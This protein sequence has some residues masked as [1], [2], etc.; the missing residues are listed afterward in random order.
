MNYQTFKTRK[1]AKMEIAKMRGWAARP[2]H[3]YLPEDPNANHE[4][5]AWVIECDGRLYLRADGY[6]R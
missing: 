3:F 4:G 6:V 2:R 5:Y 1:Q